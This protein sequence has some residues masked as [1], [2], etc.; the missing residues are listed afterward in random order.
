MK[1]RFSLAFLILGSLAC[2]TKQGLAE[3]REARP[4]FMPATPAAARAIASYT[5]AELVGAM[6]TREVPAGHPFDA[7]TELGSL[8]AAWPGAKDKM[9]IDAM[10]Q[11]VLDAPATSEAGELEV[12][13]EDVRYVIQEVM[14]VS[15]AEKADAFVRIVAAQTDPLKQKRARK[16]ARQMFDELLDVRLLAYEKED[17]DDAT[18]Y[19]EQYRIVETKPRRKS[20]VRAD[21]RRSLLGAVN[22]TLKMGIDET[23]FKMADEAAGCAALKSWLT[24]HWTEVGN[25][26]AE[27]RAD[28][29]RV[30]PVV[31][32]HAWDARW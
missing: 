22:G 3:E 14:D 16:F 19:T 7:V 26:C 31:K 8:K 2:L 18:E 10:V 13:F 29:D 30:R 24:G 17:L 25:R 12:A 15:D 27:L 21:A 9:K 23:R 32:V 4:A 1:N 5:A 11:I 6:V 20:S 28:P